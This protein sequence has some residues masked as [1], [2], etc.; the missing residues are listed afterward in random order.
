[1]DFRAVERRREPV[2]NAVLRGERRG[3]GPGAE[4]AGVHGKLDLREVG[5]PGLESG[6][7]RGGVGEDGG[8]ELGVSGEDVEL[9][10]LEL[11]HWE[12]GRER[13]RREEERKRG[14]PPKAASKA[15]TKAAQRS[16]R[17]D[18]VTPAERNVERKYHRP[19]KSYNP[20][21]SQL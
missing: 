7:E 4:G 17:T 6:L 15:A 11:L 16:S 1:M 19:Q 12:R 14:K 18:R 9:P 3:T 5:L 2:W 10:V 20:A 13:E 21:C 8:V